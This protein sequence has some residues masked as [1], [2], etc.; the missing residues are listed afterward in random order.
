MLLLGLYA[1]EQG[2]I[3]LNGVG[4][5]RLNLG[6]YRQHFSAVFSDFHLFD[7]ILCGDQR[8]IATKA[9][10]YLEKLG[11]AHKIMIESSRFSTTSL[12][13]RTTQTDG[14]SLVLPRRPS[15]LSVR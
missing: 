5:D 6:D 8:E 1:P 9:T 14:A 13:S 4:V 7:E 11:L 3:V 15:D 12:F 10:N 2:S